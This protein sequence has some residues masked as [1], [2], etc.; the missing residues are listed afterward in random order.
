MAEIKVTSPRTKPS[1]PNHGCPLDGCGFPLP[2]KGTGMCPIS[3]A[4]FSFEVDVE[5][6]KTAG[7]V[8]KDKMGNLEIVAPWKII[9]K[10]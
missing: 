9:G 1:C 4:E 5:E 8:T 2:K 3:G 7:K 10:D 6:A